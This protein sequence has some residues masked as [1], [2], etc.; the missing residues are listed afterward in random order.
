MKNRK[1][2]IAPLPFLLLIGLLLN[3]GCR[4]DSEVDNPTVSPTNSITINIEDTYQTIRGFGGCNG[5]FRGVSNF[6]KERDMQKAYGTG[7]LELG[8]SIFR[9]SVPAD[10]TRWQAVFEVAKFAQERGAIVI[11]S[12]W[13]APSEMLDPNHHE[14]RILPTKY[15]DYVAHL[16]SFNRY[17]KDNGV[18]LHAIS[19]QNE[20]DI[21]EWTQWT[22]EEVFDFTKNF[23]G[24]IENTVITAESFNFKRVYSDDI[25]N[26]SV[27][28]NNI[29]IVGGHIYG[30]G[31]G[32]YPL[33]VEKGKEVWMTEY[34]LNE[35]TDDIDQN[36]WTALT[37]SQKWNQTMDMLHSIHESML[38]NWN[39]YIWWYLKRYYGFI[40]DGLE[41][42]ADGA[43]LKRGYAFSHFSK[44]IRPGYTRVGLENKGLVRQSM[45]AYQGEGK[46]VL[47][48]INDTAS[49][50]ST[51]ISIDGT[52]FTSATS[53][54]TNINENRTA[55]ELSI[56]ENTVSLAIASSSVT[57]VVL[58]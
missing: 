19:I 23:A 29:E 54:V 56:E 40:G 8:M 58:E 37:Q 45:T 48:I 16:N 51:K 13:D 11:A 39:A 49:D 10:P 5:V 20:P 41:G 26:D 22:V 36:D 3:Q 34:L 14:K 6:P 24:D 57:T 17:M 18:Q 44:Y 50:T 33:A 4:N 2:F 52:T 25:L 35:F 32:P 53:Y 27:A 55:K 12:P 30:N 28:V 31:L 21:G 9:V 47:V 46:V 7:E 43:V 42:S 1:H 15:A 38:S